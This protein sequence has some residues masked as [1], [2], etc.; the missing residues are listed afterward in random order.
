MMRLPAAASGRQRCLLALAAGVWLL[1]VFNVG[2]RLHLQPVQQWDESLY[3]TSAWEMLQTGE[4]VGHTFRGQLD[5]YNTK[6]PLNIW[7]IVVSLRAFGLNLVT[8]RLPSIAATLLSVAVILWWTRRRVGAAASLFAGLVLSSMFAFFYVHAGRTANTDAINTLLII[9]AVVVVSEAREGR[10]R[11]LWLGPIFAAVFLLR[12]M[13]VI[14]P[15]AIALVGAAWSRQVRRDRL[16]PT[17]AALALFAV[18]VAA[19]LIARYRLDGWEF[20]GR[21]FWYD[22]VQRSVSN[23]EDHPGTVFYYLNILQKHHYDWLV[24]AAVAWLL[25]PVSGA[26][27]RSVA[28]AL[29]TRTGTL[30][31]LA[32]WALV[33]FVIPTVMVTKLAWYLHPFYPVFAIAVGALLAHAWEAAR[34]QGAPRWRR[35]TLAAVV[36]LAVGVAEGRMVWYSYHHRSLHGSPQGLLLDQRDSLR[37]RQVF[38]ARW[39]R[40]DIFVAEAIVGSRHRLAADLANFLRD[41]RP[42]DFFVSPTLLWHDAVMLVDANRRGHL[43]RRAK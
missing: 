4:W 35:R 5:Y 33:A 31:V 24:A 8:I 25:F 29:R 14:M 42:G 23:I 16:A 30:P 27:L 12:G 40:A 34:A 37:G 1:A 15:A 38:A 20:I 41:S 6:P 11:L 36:V 17:A 19:W 10:W 18:P 32:A 2:F 13:A 7:L 22:F 21:L 9:L 43:Y 3:A 28:A 26:R 39:D